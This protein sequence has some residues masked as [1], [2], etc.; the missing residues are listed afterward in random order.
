MNYYAP[1]SS[2]DLQNINM[3]DWIDDIGDIK[4]FAVLGF[5]HQMGKEGYM[6]SKGDS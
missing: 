6:I 4:D 1:L 5:L 2:E 3:G